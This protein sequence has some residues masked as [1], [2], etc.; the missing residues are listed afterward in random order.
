VVHS[1]NPSGMGRGF[2]TQAGSGIF[3]RLIANANAQKFAKQVLS[4]LAG[5][6]I[7]S[8]VMPLTSIVTA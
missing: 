3:L 4:S 8:K 7:F 6:Q 1:F 5:N 2:L